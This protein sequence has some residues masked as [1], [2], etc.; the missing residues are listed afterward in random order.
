MALVSRLLGQVTEEPK[1][2]V[3]EYTFD[4]KKSREVLGMEYK[5]KQETAK[6]MLDDFKAKGW[7]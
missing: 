2:I 1:D 3:Y 6:F 4:T 7:L 5:T